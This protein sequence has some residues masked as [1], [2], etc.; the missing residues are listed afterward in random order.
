MNN[1]LRGFGNLKKNENGIMEYVD[2]LGVKY[3]YDPTIKK[4][5]SNG[6][7]LTE[8]ALQDLEISE[9]EGVG[10][11]ADDSGGGKK[12]TPQ[13][14]QPVQYKITTNL[15]EK[16]RSLS[17]LEVIIPQLE[18]NNIGYGHIL[19][20]ST[21]DYTD[22]I[23]GWLGSNPP[24]CDVDY[25]QYEINVQDHIDE[26]SSTYTQFNSYYGTIPEYMTLNFFHS[27]N[28]F[29][30]LH[31]LVRLTQF[32]GNSY[33]DVDIT[34]GIGLSAIN[35]LYSTLNS[36]TPLYPQS[37]ISH[38][39][40]QTLPYFFLARPSG[41]DACTW[42]YQY[43]PLNATDTALLQTY[44]S[45]KTRLINLL[46]DRVTQLLANTDANASILPAF[47][48]TYS[49]YYATVTLPH[50]SNS[51][52][53]WVSKTCIAIKESC[54]D[55]KTEAYVS[56]VVYEGSEYTFNALRQGNYS[57]PLN[58]LKAN[59]D[60]LPSLV[61]RSS[62][63]KE[64]ILDPIRD[65]GITTVHIWHPWLYF[66]D[67]AKQTPSG[68]TTVGVTDVEIFLNR[69]ILNDLFID[70]NIRSAIAIDNTAAWNVASVED[71]VIAAVI[72]K[73]VEIANN[74]RNG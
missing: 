46:K 13:P 67:V 42:D 57:L 65:S 7:I 2:Y 31:E 44:A 30:E 16:T 25:A 21:L 35:M 71:D 70:Q 56:S 50:L 33:V 60:A 51:T 9:Q 8:A 10:D 12:S 19:Y 34:S 49:E 59:V 11:A 74:I 54:G 15:P 23:T 55:R 18:Q 29:V 14:S 52:K 17:E 68:S 48:M 69:K 62:Y 22:P 58:Q 4:W 73:D 3:T 45:E 66:F 47:Y 39:G 6:R 38:F 36:T 43:T 63:M 41:G 37:E 28:V 40:Y 64:V 5:K 1:F 32:Q 27:P 61:G 53:E 26:W 20:T 24:C 72:S